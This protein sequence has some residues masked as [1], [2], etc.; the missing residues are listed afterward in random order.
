MLSIKSYSV[1][2]TNI[3]VCELEVGAPTVLVYFTSKFNLSRDYIIFQLFGSFILIGIGIFLLFRS[4][5]IFRGVIPNNHL[6]RNIVALLIIEWFHWGMAPIFPDFAIMLKQMGWM[7][8]AIV[9]SLIAGCSTLI[10][11]NIAYWVTNNTYLKGQS[12]LLHQLIILSSIILS[13]IVVILPVNYYFNHYS[14]KYFKWSMAW[15]FYFG[16][17][18]ASINLIINYINREKEQREKILELEIVKLNGLRVKDK[19]EALQSKINPHFLYNTLNSIAD[20]SITDGKKSREM[21][22]AL[23]DLFRYNIDQ[24]ESLYCTVEEEV[25]MATTYL[26]IEKIRFEDKLSYQSRIQPETAKLLIPKFLLQ[27]LVENAVKHGL[28]KLSSCC[29]IKIETELY[30]DA[31]HIKIYDNG[32]FFTE[33]LAPGF[34]MRNVMEKLDLIYQ[35]KYELAFLNS[36]EKHVLIILKN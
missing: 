6:R 11:Y 25:R 33:E 26:N 2:G 14:T 9:Y 20:L 30:D 5:T 7:K 1:Y 12:F 34:G 4:K 24:S 21:T 19:L 31:L 32:P 17:V 27:P 3:Q 18:V 16:S 10:V 29:I 22:L 13:T 8:T 28:K 23:S 36:P 35:S 15:S